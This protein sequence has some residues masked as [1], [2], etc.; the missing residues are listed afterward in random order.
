ME[1]PG[2]AGGAVRVP[3]IL[4]HP[5]HTS[6]LA[7]SLCGSLIAGKRYLVD[8]KSGCAKCVLVLVAETP[9]AVLPGNEQTTG[10]GRELA[11]GIVFVLGAGL[12]G[13]CLT[14]TFVLATSAYPGYAAPVV[15]WA[16]GR[17][18]RAGSKD[19]SGRR[20]RFAAAVMTYLSG[21]LAEVPVVMAQVIARGGA[22]NGWS[23]HGAWSQFPLISLFASLFSPVLLLHGF[24]DV[25][26]AVF[27]AGGVYVAYRVGAVKR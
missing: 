23:G 6:T 7:C 3:E 22:P 5:D 25:I 8:G 9:G 11:G 12:L 24:L 16:V 1:M 18:V 19:A 15:G 20:Y 21:C 17:A 13:L 26:G 2:D 10:G 27:L 14:A 4:V